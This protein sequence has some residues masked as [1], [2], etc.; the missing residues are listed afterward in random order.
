MGDMHI[1][2]LI[3][4]VSEYTYKGDL[5]YRIA[6]AALDM[7]EPVFNKKGEQICS[8]GGFGGQGDGKCSDF[9]KVAKKQRVIFPPAKK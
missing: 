7:T 3:A 1:H 2:P 6:L 5:I 9:D 4:E 8:L